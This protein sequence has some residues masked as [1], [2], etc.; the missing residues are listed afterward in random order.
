MTV[1]KRLALRFHS[2][3]QVRNAI[4]DETPFG[5]GIFSCPAEQG[6]ERQ[7]R[8]SSDHPP[9]QTAI[10]NP[11]PMRTIGGAG[12][13]SLFA[14]AAQVERFQ[15]LLLAG[16]VLDEAIG[17]DVGEGVVVG[18]F[19]EKFQDALGLDVARIVHRADHLEHLDRERLDFERVD[20]LRAE[21]FDLARHK[22]A[23]PARNR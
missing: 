6:Q 20:F 1:C 5:T 11:V 17:H 10:P 22:R 16:D 7:A 19:V 2:P 8:L 18:D 14:G 4:R 13:R 15:D 12:R 3:Q 9:M 21:N 23:F